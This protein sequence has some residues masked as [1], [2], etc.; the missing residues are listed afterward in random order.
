MDVKYQPWTTT[1]VGCGV[2]M[3]ATR[4]RA[5]QNAV[6]SVGSRQVSK[7][8]VRGSPSHSPKR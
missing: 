2:G 5:A 7:S 6:S 4:R 1:Y 8:G 3:S